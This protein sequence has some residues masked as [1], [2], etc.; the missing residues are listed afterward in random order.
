MQFMQ[1]IEISTDRID[2]LTK[3]EDDWRSAARGRR[4]G[5]A[6]WLCADR[7][8]PERYFSVNL[9]PS[10]DAAIANGALPETDALA[11]QA[12]QIGTA[13]FHDCDVV[14]DLW[15]NELS[16]QS[17]RLVAMF[18]TGTVPDGLFT[19]DV[20]VEL[21]VPH[22]SLGIEGLATVRSRFP[23]MVSLGTVE[24]HRFLPAVG[25]FVIEIALRAAAYSRQVCVARTRGG[26]IEHLSI[27]CT[28]DF[29]N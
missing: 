14:Q 21:N 11:A 9:F 5:I 19:D 23:E 10:Y 25:G 15:A 18:A 29:P 17:E 26:L 4:T 7:S 20:V 24:E 12:M 22:A 2:D 1:I 13:T 8:R 27:Y 28:G 3:L 16:S 6:D